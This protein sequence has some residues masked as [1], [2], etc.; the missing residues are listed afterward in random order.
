M[1]QPRTLGLSRP[2]AQRTFI[3]GVV[4]FVI[5]SVW[6]ALGFQAA[7]AGDVRVFDIDNEPPS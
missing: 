5:G 2:A 6:A 3:V 7:G 1:K 4:V